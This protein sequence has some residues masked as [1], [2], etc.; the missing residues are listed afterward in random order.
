MHLLHGHARGDGAHRVDEAALHQVAQAFGV[1]RP[2]AQRSRRRRDRFRSRDDADEELDDDL[3]AHAVRGDQ[4]LVGGALHLDAQG[5]HADFGDVV[6][7][8]QDQRAAAHHHLLAAPAGAD[9]GEVLRRVAVEPVQQ[10]HHHRN[11]DREQDDDRNDV[12]ATHDSFLR[13]IPTA[14]RRDGQSF[15]PVPSRMP[16]ARMIRPKA[17]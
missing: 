3:D 13:S 1:H 11:D 4:R 17:I 6:H 2:V 9:E 8:R 7:D 14:W 12:R 15:R 5:V 16:T 10:V